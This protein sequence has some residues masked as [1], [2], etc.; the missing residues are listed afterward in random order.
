L[1][2]GEIDHYTMEK[3]YI[4]RDGEVVWVMLAVSLAHDDE[5]QPAHYVAQMQDITASRAAQELLAHRALHDPLT[6][7]ANRDLLMD[8]LAHA[9]SRSARSARPTVVLFCD[10]DHFK[11]VND[12]LGHETGDLVLVTIADR[13][14]ALV[15]TSDTV[16][17][18]GGD[19][20]VIVAEGLRTPAEQRA[21][22]DRIRSALHEPV[23][24]AGSVVRTGASI[25][26]A[27]S[28]P[29]DDA[30]SLLREADAT[31]YRAK[32]RGR[33]RY[34]VSDAMEEL[35]PIGS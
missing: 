2:A 1:R 15:R 19:E 6:G 32:A 29:E 18:L 16:A 27:V 20:F 24:V 7:L 3:R 11:D 23:A 35:G 10:L 12:D 25:G 30:R 21:L 8:R 22:A 13:L 4:T 34:E 5:D 31:M 9:L 28:R 14:T 33:G 17:R 26:L